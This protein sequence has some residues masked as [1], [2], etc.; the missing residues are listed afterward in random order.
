MPMFDKTVRKM[1]DSKED[2][3]E[4]LRKEELFKERMHKK[5]EQWVDEEDPYEEIRMPLS[6]EDV[7]LINNKKLRFVKIFL[8]LMA[9]LIAVVW[10]LTWGIP[11]TRIYLLYV[12]GAFFMFGL[13]FYYQYRFVIKA[14]KL[15]IKG[16]ILEKKYLEETKSMPEQFIFCISDKNEIEVTHK[17]YWTYTLGDIVEIENVKSTFTINNKIRLVGSIKV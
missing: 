14:G 6:E 16:V 1:A 9:V 5:Y 13:Y 17:D 15:I 8:S 7:P 2:R 3:E 4:M 12:P 10:Y 11:E